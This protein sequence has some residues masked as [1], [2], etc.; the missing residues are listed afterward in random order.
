VTTED[1]DKIVHDHLISKGTYPSILN[2]WT[3]PRSCFTSVNEI[4]CHGIPDTRPLEEGDI[5]NVEVT[6][7]KDGF[8]GSLSETFCVGKVDDESRQLVEDAYY[9]VMKAIDICEPN[10]C[11]R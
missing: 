8:N 7:L 2:W 9:S 3:F 1:I 5:I 4:M 6:G 11:Y 10:A